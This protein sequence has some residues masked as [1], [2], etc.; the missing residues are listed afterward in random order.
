[1]TRATRTRPVPPAAGTGFHGYGYG[2][3]SRKG[4]FTRAPHYL[5]EDAGVHYAAAATELSTDCPVNC[6][7]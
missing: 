7:P 4:G 3:S 5:P 6:V 2:L 1:M